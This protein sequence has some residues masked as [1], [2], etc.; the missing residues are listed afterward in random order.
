MASW[1]VGGGAGEQRGC[2][3]ALGVSDHSEDH[4]LSAGVALHLP[5]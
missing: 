4:Q 1:W 5:W 2:S 3:R